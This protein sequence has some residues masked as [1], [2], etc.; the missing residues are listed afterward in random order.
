MGLWVYLLYLSNHFLSLPAWVIYGAF[1]IVSAGLLFFLFHRYRSIL[2][3]QH[4]F[5]THPIPMWI[6]ECGTLRFL[7]VNQ[8]AIE[9]YGFS[10]KEFLSLTIK[11]IRDPEE[12][13]K[14]VE[15]RRLHQDGGHA[16]NRCLFRQQAGARHQVA[17][18]PRRRDLEQEVVIDFTCG[19]TRHESS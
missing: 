1:A 17:W 9:K 10:R 12:A 2:Q 19:S 6:Y 13:E 3:F 4:V 18:H 7:A 8:A 11:D 16:A 15:N 5:D 14:V